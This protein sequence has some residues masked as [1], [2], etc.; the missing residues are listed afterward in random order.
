[1]QTITCNVDG[2]TAETVLQMQIVLVVLQQLHA[3]NEVKLIKDKNQPWN[4]C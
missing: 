2:R 1:M 4:V 3:C